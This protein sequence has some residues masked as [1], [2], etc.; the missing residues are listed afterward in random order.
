MKSLLEPRK[1]YSSRVFSIFKKNGNGLMNSMKSLLACFASVQANI[2][3]AD[4]GFNLVY[5]N[6][7]AL[8]TLKK[9]EGEISDEFDVSLE[10]LVGSS[11]HRFHKDPQR[12]EKILRNPSALPHTAEF[13]FGGVTL[14]ATINSFVDSC[15]MILGYVVNWEDVSKTN[16]TKRSMDRVNSMM[17][18]APV[19]VIFAE[20]D[21]F[22]ITYVNPSSIK[23]LSTIEQYLPVKVDQLLNQSIDIFHKNPAHQRKL[24]SDPA[25]LPH[26]T[27]IQVGPEILNLLVSAIYDEN[28]TYL[29]P[30]VTWEVVTQKLITENEVA[31][32]NSMMENAP[33]NVLF[34][35]AETFNITYANPAS[36]TT[37]K[38][39]EQYLPIPIDKLIGQS[40]DVFHKNPAHQR[41]ILADPNNLPHR[42]EIQVG[43]ETLDL[44]VSAIY[45]KNKNYLGPMVTW[46]VITEKR[47]AEKREREMSETMKNILADVSEKAQTL[48]GASEELTA[49]SQQMAG[50]AEETSAQ[51]TVV[52]AASDH[53]NLNIQTVATGSEEMSASI[54]EIAH[55]ANQATQVTS[56]AVRLAETTNKTVTQLGVSSAEIGQVI[57]VITSI[58]EQTNLLA[59]NATIEAAR[60]G[61]AGKGFAVVANEVKEL[62][63]QTAKATEDISSKIQAIQ[64]DAQSAVTAIGEI[65]TVIGQI[66]DIFNTIASAVEEQS[67]T[68]N[69][70]T[71]NV[72]EA[73]KGSQEIAENIASV[74]Q[75]A[76]STN[77][78]ATDMQAAASELAKL[79]VDMQTLVSQFNK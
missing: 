23:T 69:E 59:L 40:I 3:V 68:T 64:T 67:A 42:A 13:S 32:V 76:Q 30:M 24:L 74:A 1:E 12:I 8:N 29:G 46:E 5:A 53:V 16:A 34:A 25:N 44:L 11:I 18:N 33:V 66:S 39:I 20:K 58:A 62:A 75:A 52:S 22:K 77:D 49:T 72:S 26:R 65:S 79:A 2:L 31:R 6:K 37:L 48:A 41:K 28:K 70:I 35:D 55:N 60:A 63:N 78:G 57:K 21:S 47:C 27:Q 45:D 9:I 73:S 51:A 14:A 10:D 4:A 61:E 43:P 56:D 17:E 15:G 19:N 50:N 36:M 38:T 54:K 7:S 71:R